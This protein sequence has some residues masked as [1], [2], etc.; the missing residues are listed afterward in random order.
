MKSI[1]LGL[2]LFILHT[3][4]VYSQSETLPFHNQVDHGYHF[5]LNLPDAYNDSSKAMPLIVFLHGYSLSGSDLNRVKKYGVIDAIQ[6]TGIK[7]NAFVVAPQCPRGQHWNPDRVLNVMNWVKKNYHIDSMRVYVVGMSMGGYGTFDFVGKYPNEVTAAMALCGGGKVS[8]AANLA[9]VPLWILHGKADRDVPV[10]QSQKM[11]NAIKKNGINY[12]RADYFPGL[13]H[14]DMVHVFYMPVMYQWLYQFDGSEASKSKINNYQIT[15]T[16]FRNRPVDG[17]F[18]A[19]SQGLKKNSKDI[20]YDSLPEIAII[21]KTSPKTEKS[22]NQKPQ[23]KKSE[24]KKIYVVKQ[25]DTLYAI[26]LKNKTTTE[27]LCKLN[28]IKE[29]SVL[30][31]GQKIRVE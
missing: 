18:G 30:K 15:L 1:F 26:A 16:D 25:G 21:H 10:S 11:E 19:Y 3:Q 5:L 20:K 29:D 14:A 6:R 23:S 2:L 12:V 17:D 24:S 9:K 7:P 31:I 13:G 22:Q 8:D 28:G 27:K 4:L